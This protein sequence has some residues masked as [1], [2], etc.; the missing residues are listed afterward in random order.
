MAVNIC[1]LI[2]KYTNSIEMAII[3]YKN[4]DFCRLNITRRGCGALIII[5]IVNVHVK[6]NMHIVR[7]QRRTCD[8]VVW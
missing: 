5:L 4:T 8:A 7:S 6:G 3:K 2:S 1:S